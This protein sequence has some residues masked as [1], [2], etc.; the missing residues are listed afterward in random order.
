MTPQARAGGGGERP[1]LFPEQRRAL[2]YVRAKGSR[3]P[4]AEVRGRVARAFAELEALLDAIP[5]ARTG[6][7]PDPA[8]WSLHEV[9]DHLIE[10]HRPAVRE[11]ELALAGSSPEGG[12]IPAGLLSPDPFRRDWPAAVAE[13]RQVHG[14]FLALLSGAGD[15]TPTTARVAVE[16]V[17]RCATPDG[18]SEPVHWID[19]F[20]W[21]AYALLV[22]LH[23][24]EHA[25]QVQRV[26]ARLG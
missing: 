13:L 3:A 21:K 18:G 15:E 2:D 16:M 11:L 9:V 1:D 14:D 6:R 5:E 24:R 8:T 23:S 22:A 10:S 26:L 7:R 12:P 4:A 19:R 17:V 20:D 25:G